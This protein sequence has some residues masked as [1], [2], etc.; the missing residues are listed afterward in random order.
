M[1]KNSS[2]C[3]PCDEIEVKLKVESVEIN[4]IR[5][6]F[7]DSNTSAWMRTYFSIS[8]LLIF[9][10]FSISIFFSLDSDEEEGVSLSS[11]VSIYHPVKAQA[12]KRIDVV[13]GLE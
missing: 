5:T 8:I 7:S 6:L 10:L 12:N 13:R 1:G 3:L 2:R 11:I 4:A 9:V